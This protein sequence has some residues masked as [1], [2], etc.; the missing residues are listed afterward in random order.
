MS[1]KIMISLEPFAAKQKIYVY[2][3]TKNTLFSTKEKSIEN[4]VDAVLATADSCLA[5]EICFIKQKEFSSK[6][7]NEIQQRELSKY[8]KTKVKVTYETMKEGA[9]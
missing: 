6:F 9:L 2:D 1:K 5:D 7:G 3:E 8:G 4:L